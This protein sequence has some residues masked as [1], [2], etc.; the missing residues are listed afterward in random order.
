MEYNSMQR[1][2]KRHT[3]LAETGKL[4]VPLISNTLIPITYNNNK[5]TKRKKEKEMCMLKDNTKS[6]G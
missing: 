3:V 5:Q 4:H 2:G 6:Y 1:I